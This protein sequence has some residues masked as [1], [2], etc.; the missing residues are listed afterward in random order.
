[1][2]SFSASTKSCIPQ[3]ENAEI[4]AVEDDV[5]LD[6]PSNDNQYIISRE[7][8]ITIKEREAH[9]N[10]PTGQKARKWLLENVLPPRL[11]DAMYFK[12]FQYFYFN[13]MHLL[14]QYDTPAH[15][16]LAEGPKKQ[17]AIR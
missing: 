8:T 4:Y 5:E 10:G 15:K 3:D 11:R 6:L 12:K 13:S 7:G 2:T 17:S 16:I 14:H 1:M 9:Q